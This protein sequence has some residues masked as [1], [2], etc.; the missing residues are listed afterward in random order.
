MVKRLTILVTTVL[1][2]LGIDFLVFAVAERQSGKRHLARTLTVIEQEG[3]SMN[4]AELRPPTIADLSNA[5]IALLPFTNR[6]AVVPDAMNSLP[7]VWIWASPGTLL[8]LKPRSS[9]N[10]AADGCVSEGTTTESRH[11]RHEV[12]PTN[13]GERPMANG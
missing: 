12:F 7:S 13:R 11:S 9:L 2:G 10:R 8:P 6:L 1:I 3:R 4:T 5:W